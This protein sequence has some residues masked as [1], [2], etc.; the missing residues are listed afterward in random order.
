[1]HKH[2]SRSMCIIRMS[3]LSRNIGSELPKFRSGQAAFCHRVRM[4]ADRKHYALEDMPLFCTQKG[5]SYHYAVQK[6][7]IRSSDSSFSRGIMPI[8]M[9]FI[10]LPSSLLE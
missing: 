10:R 8:E 7:L 5:L 9:R 1:V 6:G 4:H 3:S 2:D